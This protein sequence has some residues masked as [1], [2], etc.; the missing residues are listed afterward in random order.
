[1]ELFNDIHKG[2]AICVIHIKYKLTNK[3]SYN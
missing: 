1:M 2:S 3:A